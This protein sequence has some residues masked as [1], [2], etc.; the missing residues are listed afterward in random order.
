MVGKSEHEDWLKETLR[1]MEAME[2]QIFISYARLY[3]Q[4]EGAREQQLKLKVEKNKRDI[5]ELLVVTRALRDFVV[6]HL[7]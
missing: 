5:A 3:R 4:G 2:K 6:L 7:K 1:Q